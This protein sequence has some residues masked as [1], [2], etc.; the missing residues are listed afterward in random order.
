MTSPSS[1]I[2]AIYS[3]VMFPFFIKKLTFC[4]LFNGY[5]SVVKHGCEREETQSA[6]DMNALMFEWLSKFEYEVI[7]GDLS[8]KSRTSKNL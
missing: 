2:N 3:F 5:F 6:Y 4:Y 8:F 7:E 1:E